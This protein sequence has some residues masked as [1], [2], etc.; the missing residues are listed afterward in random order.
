MVKISCHHHRNL[1][2]TLRLNK[3]LGIYKIVVIFILLILLKKSNSMFIQ[4]V[5]NFWKSAPSFH[6]GPQGFNSGCQGKCR[7]FHLVS[8]SPTQ[9][10]YPS[11]NIQ[12]WSYLDPEIHYFLLKIL[13]SQSVFSSIWKSNTVRV[14]T[15][16][17]R[18][19]TFGQDCEV[20]ATKGLARVPGVLSEPAQ[21]EYSVQSRQTVNSPS[22]LRM[23]GLSGGGA[24]VLFILTMHPTHS[25]GPQLLTAS[26]KSL[27]SFF[28]KTQ[29][30]PS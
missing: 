30:S 29:I 21:G 1:E 7:H 9:M 5:N 11:E 25:R 18:L 17:L 24:A 23:W 27:G 8:L 26:T 22:S 28:K 19:P 10:L 15:Q 14:L 3:F 12:Y 16:G 2:N 6:C 20:T 13:R 4:C